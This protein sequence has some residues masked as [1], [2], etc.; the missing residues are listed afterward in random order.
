[1][2]QLLSHL[3]ASR[4]HMSTREGSAA[5]YPQQQSL[6][7]TSAAKN[8]LQHCASM[9]KWGHADKQQQHRQSD[10]YCTCKLHAN[11]TPVS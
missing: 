10:C 3:Q 5:T 6:K 7:A 4:Q 2:L 8:T 1:M 9:S 11:T